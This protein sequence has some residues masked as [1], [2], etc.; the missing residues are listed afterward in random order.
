ML[1]IITNKNGAKVLWKYGN[2]YGNG[3]SNPWEYVVT[4]SIKVREIPKAQ[5]DN[6]EWI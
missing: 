4:R 5:I 2:M 6:T 1:R 3:Y